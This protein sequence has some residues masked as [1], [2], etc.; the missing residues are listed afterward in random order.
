MYFRKRTEF[1]PIPELFDLGTPD[2]Y[3]SIIRLIRDDRIIIEV[4]ILELLGFL[5]FDHMMPY[6]SFPETK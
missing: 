6:I 1:R 5:T 4:L 3:R 2:R